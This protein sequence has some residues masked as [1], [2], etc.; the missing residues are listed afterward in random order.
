M[1]LTQTAIER[2][3]LL[4]PVPATPDIVTE[5]DELVA[6]NDGDHEPEGPDEPG[7]GFPRRERHWSFRRKGAKRQAGPRSVRFSSRRWRVAQ[8]TLATVAVVLVG[9][10]AELTVLGGLEHRSTQITLFNQFRSELALGTGAVG[11]VGSDHRPIALGTPIG[12]LAIP[13][14]GVRQVIAQGTTAAVLTGGPGH[15]RSTVFPG[16]DGTSVVLGRAHAY[17][18]PFSRIAD[19]RKG[20][21]ITVVTQAGT[22]TFRVVDVH[23]AGARVLG[24]VPG[25][26]RLTLGTASGTPFAPSGVVWVDA[27]K[28]GRPL[29][30][31]RPL[32]RTVP[33]SEQP[34]GIDTGSLWLFLLGLE[35]LAAVLI[36]AAWSWRRF[37]RA[38]AWIVFSAPVLLVGVFLADQLA[39]FL[40]N[41]T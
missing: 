2:E 21:T 7:S 37:G 33:A 41:L 11:P 20:A 22:A 5:P 9:L 10:V 13:S 31:F 32:L 3:L 30:S 36:L 26:S 16:G 18:G 6:D 19:L 25:T 4:V 34:L 38:Q 1:T 24:P 17:G 40:P 23:A 35:A 28:V 14:I 12:L 15:L 29:P 39:R 27:D 8:L